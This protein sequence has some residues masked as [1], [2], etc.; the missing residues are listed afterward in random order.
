[1]CASGTV[2]VALYDYYEIRPD[3]NSVNLDRSFGSHSQ[4]MYS[5]TWTA[6]ERD[7]SFWK[8]KNK[9][10]EAKNEQRLMW[11]SGNIPDS[12]FFRKDCT[13]IER[14]EVVF[15]LKN[16]VT[17]KGESRYFDLHQIGRE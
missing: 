16:G 6:D 5:E 13:N 12:K 4:P 8:F 17:L 2:T 14:V 11:F 10:T 9:A 1:M 3:P 7:F 15:R